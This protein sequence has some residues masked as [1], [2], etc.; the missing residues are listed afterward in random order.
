LGSFLVQKVYCNN[1]TTRE[2]KNFWVKN[3]AEYCKNLG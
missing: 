3:I 2:L 1:R